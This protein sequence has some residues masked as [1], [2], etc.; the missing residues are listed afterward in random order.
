MTSSSDHDCEDYNHEG[1][2]SDGYNYEGYD[3]EG[4]DRSGFNRDGYN[5]EGYD[6]NGLNRERYDRNGYGPYDNDGFD[7][8][9]YDVAG[10]DSD[11]IHCITG[12]YYNE[13]GLDWFN[14]ILSIASLHIIISMSQIN[15]VSS[16][17][18]RG[19]PVR[20]TPE[21]HD[22]SSNSNMNVGYVCA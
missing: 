7:Q 8:D 17:H 3:Y 12:D 5:H 15:P 14:A 21:V 4:Y 1:Y 16:H 9:G 18:I 13:N 20:E 11:R 19:I 22:S 10:F 2:Y 6:I